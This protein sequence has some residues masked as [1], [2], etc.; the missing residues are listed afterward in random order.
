MVVSFSHKHAPLSSTSKLHNVVSTRSLGRQN[1]LS[2][3]LQLLHKVQEEGQG[4]TIFRFFFR[5]YTKYKLKGQGRSS[6]FPSW[7]VF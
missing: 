7:D 2:F 6:A 1:R 3:L 4:R 5:C